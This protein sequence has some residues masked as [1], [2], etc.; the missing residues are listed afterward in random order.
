MEAQPIHADREGDLLHRSKKRIP[1][2]RLKASGQWESHPVTRVAAARNR[3]GVVL[4]S[5]VTSYA[6]LLRH[7]G[8]NT[9]LL[10]TSGGTAPRSEVKMDPQEWEDSAL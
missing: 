9:M 7:S 8:G 1:L 10:T 6:A 4:K 2:L 5:K 3:L